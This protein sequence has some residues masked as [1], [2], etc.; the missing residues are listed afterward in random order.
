MRFTAP[1]LLA[2]IAIPVAALGMLGTVGPLAA[3]AAMGLSDLT[4]IGNALRLKRRL[5]RSATRMTP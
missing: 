5:G 4:V 3:A 2:W 1:I